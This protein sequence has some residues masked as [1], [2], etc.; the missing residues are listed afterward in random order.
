MKSI[1]VWQRRT[2]LTAAAMVIGGALVGVSLN[3]TVQV[4]VLAVLV[5]LL[6]LPHGALDPLVAH[7]AG[8]WD[9]VRSFTIFIGKYLLLA[10][11]ALLFWIFVPGLAL[12]AFLLYSGYHFS[13]DW[14]GELPLPSRLAA[15][16]FIVSMP[17]AIHAGLTHDIFAILAGSANASWVLGTMQVIAVPA[18]LGLAL[19]ILFHVK[20]N[21]L[22]LELATLLITGLLLPPILFFVLYFC[23]LHSPRHLIHAAAGAP[24]R[25]VAGTAILFTFLTCALAALALPF[26]GGAPLSD[27]LVRFVFIGLAALT[28]PHMILVEKATA[29]RQG[30]KRRQNSPTPGSGSGR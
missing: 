7:R 2:F 30:K 12:L 11:C 27:T 20:T 8:V 22:R 6:G 17:S 25:L 1:A 5:V 10:A 13:G 19:A 3:G 14:D 23:A 18:G 26:M 24:F 9:D 21:A 28:V 4:Y 29:D 16:F 15:G